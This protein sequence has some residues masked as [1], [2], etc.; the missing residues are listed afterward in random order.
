M[1]KNKTRRFADLAVLPTAVWTMPTAS[2][3]RS[4][5]STVISEFD[6]KNRQSPRLYL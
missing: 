2:L 1:K 3:S 4:Q 5:Q 6:Y